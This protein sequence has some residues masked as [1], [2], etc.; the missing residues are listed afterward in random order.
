MSG[1]NNSIE[2][3][4]SW[5]QVADDTLDDSSM[6]E[7]G[8]R[9]VLEYQSR[10]ELAQQ[11]RYLSEILEYPNIN[12]EPIFEIQLNDGVEES[13]FAVLTIP[14]LE[15]TMS[16]RSLHRAAYGL[17][18]EL[19][20]V[21]AEPDLGSRVFHDPLPIEDVVSEEGAVKDAVVSTCW[22][23]EPPPEDIHWALKALRVNSAWEIGQEKGAGIVIGQPD[24]GVA[25]H[26]EL[27]AEQIDFTKAFNF[28]EGTDDPTD[29]LESTAA[30]PGH[31]TGTASVAVS[32]SEG[33]MIGSAPGAKLVPIRCI[34]DVKVFNAAPVAKAIEHA[35]LAG[36]DVIT[37]S[38]G[39]TP[40][41]AVSRAIDRAVH[42]N[43]IV[44]AAAGNCVRTVVWP[45]RYRNVIAI[46]GC[47][48]GDEPW[49]GS[50]RGMEVDVC[51]P[52]E[53][54]WRAR[55]APESNDT[56]LVEAGQG[57]SFAVALTSGIAALWLA[58]HGR[59][60]VVAA[61]KAQGVSVQELFRTLVKDTARKPEG[62]NSSKFGA[63]I[64]NAQALL[65]RDL[66]NSTI[67]AMEG[68][69][70]R[71]G[72]LTMMQEFTGRTFSAVDEFPW[73]RFSSELGAVLLD[74]AGRGA[75]GTESVPR[76]P[77]SAELEKALLDNATSDDSGV[78]FVNQS[79]VLDRG[80]EVVPV[81][82]VERLN[83]IAVK[84]D[85]A[86][87]SVSTRA[88]SDAR[89]TLSD[90]AI[91]EKIDRL[92]TSFAHLPEHAQTPE[93]AASRDE[94]LVNADKVLHHLREDK[95]IE[96]VIGL[97][98]ALEALVKLEGRPVLEM[99]DEAIDY[100]AP[101]L[102]PWQ[103]RIILSKEQIES[104]RNSIGRID[105]RGKHAGT[106]Y[107]VAPGLIMTNRH[108]LEV[109]AT[110]LPRAKSPD[111]WLF[112][113]A[114]T[115]NFSPD[116]RDPGREFQITEVVF[117]GADPIL[118]LPVSFRKLD[119]ALLAVESTNTVGTSLPP[120]IPITALDGL[121]ERGG[122]MIVLGYPA[123]PS[124]LPQ[125]SEG[126][127]RRDVVDRLR[128][129]Y[130]LRYG[131]KYLSMGEV[132]EGAENLSASPNNWVFSHDATSLG[133]NSGSAVLSLSGEVTLTGLHFA[134]D[135]LR[136]NYAHD[137]TKVLAQV[138]MPLPPARVMV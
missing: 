60:T 56:D 129:L 97:R 136:A 3:L 130:G 70:G 94:L 110:P 115:V 111:V 11:K 78:R 128:K 103:G 71:D 12:I 57:T 108:V 59:D 134:G 8:L 2:L 61:S 45:A 64:V 50:S 122:S 98:T 17:V 66:S 77:I 92:A 88:L 27:E 135:W 31:G 16:P 102:G 120:P 1:S 9:F 83:M 41:R 28:V 36:V 132:M 100:D 116:A 52:A 119:L 75:T 6:P 89:S 105:I 29:P 47:N 95:P 124:R 138:E 37:M 87:E 131:V 43:I 90:S 127:T 68:S 23:D 20:L 85:T 21:S 40:S 112:E 67:L 14:G 18:D 114:A 55:R 74:S 96:N 106:G 35:R 53:L 13:F 118:D 84:P 117:A 48:D 39:G 109:I 15:R 25:D 79:T 5:C 73:D 126:R 7:R 33:Q 26:V 63:G 99:T 101:N 32:A 22:V 125:D 34:N 93:L 133:G 121:V 65:E 82:D 49:R 46:G 69:D 44:L 4:K 107:V 81:A 76:A 62:W 10:P 91:Q 51:A 30:N 72:L 19:D 80:L 123:P 113:E 54:V 86:L 58:H 24:T 104:T 137:L 38:L 42:S